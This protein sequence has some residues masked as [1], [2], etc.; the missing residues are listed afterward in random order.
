MSISQLL[1]EKRFQE[2]GQAKKS[3]IRPHKEMSKTRDKTG[4]NTRRKSEKAEGGHLLSCSLGSYREK[5]K[6]T[7]PEKEP[8][9]RKKF[10]QARNICNGLRKRNKE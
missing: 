4:W 9:E 3:W 1:H 10:L 2:S 5:L 7:N 8:E 6:L